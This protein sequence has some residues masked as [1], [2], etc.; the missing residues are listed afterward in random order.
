MK[1]LLFVLMCVCMVSMAQAAAISLVNA[2]FEQP[3][4][5]KISHG[6]DDVNGCPGLEQRRDDRLG[7]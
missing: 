4:A 7:Y 6:F 3:A 5:G 1:K 2:G